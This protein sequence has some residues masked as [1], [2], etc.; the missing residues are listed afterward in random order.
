VVWEL[1]SALMSSSPL[2][3]EGVLLAEEAVSMRV[4]G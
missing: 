3:E 4:S 1:V 2:A